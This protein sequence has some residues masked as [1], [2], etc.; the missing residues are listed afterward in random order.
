MSIL[1]PSKIIKHR[2]SLNDPTLSLNDPALWDEMFGGMK[3]DAGISITPTKALGIAAVYQAVSAISGDIARMPL[4]VHDRGEGPLE[5][6]NVVK[7]HPLENVLSRQANRLEAPVRMWRRAMVHN[8]IWNHAFIFISRD[9]SGVPEELIP[10]LP[11]RTNLEFRSDGTPYVVTERGDGTLQAL[12]YDDVL[13][14]QGVTIGPQGDCELIALARNQWANAL[15]KQKFE[16]KYFKNGGRVGGILELPVGMSKSARDTVEEGFRKSYEGPDQAFKTVILRD[17]AKFHQA[18]HSPVDSQV[19]E[20]GEAQVRDIARWFNMPPTRLGLDGGGWASKSE[21]RQGYIDFTLSIW[22]SLII[23]EAQVKLLSTEDRIKY[24]L[25]HNTSVL[26]AMNPTERAAYYDSMSR[27]R[28]MNPNEIRNREGMQPYKGGD[29]FANPNTMKDGSPAAPK[30]TTRPS[31]LSKLIYAV[32]AR[33]RDKAKRPKVFVDWIDN[34]VDKWIQE[35]WRAMHEPD[36][37]PNEVQEFVS[38]LK[39]VLETKKEAE[40]QEAVEREAKKLEG[41]Q[42]E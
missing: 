25:R 8:L 22:L 42:D 34:H 3:T 40:L 6:G 38:S 20:T 24:V 10:L 2:R 33:A 14:I 18:Q 30:T 21:D 15:A 32:A 11:D 26:L 7:D 36:E 19:I 1:N 17:G 23:E 29:E 28:A 27:N 9:E 39:R 5:A 41:L 31:R 12:P 4:Q 16:A 35:E 37:P 13:H